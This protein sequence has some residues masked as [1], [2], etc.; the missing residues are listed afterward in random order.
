LLAQIEFRGP[1]TYSSHGQ[2]APTSPFV[3]QMVNANTGL[4]IDGWGVAHDP[5]P[6][7]VFSRPFEAE[8]RLF[9]FHNQVCATVGILPNVRSV[10]RP[11]VETKQA[12]I[13]FWHVT[14]G[15][16]Y[17]RTALP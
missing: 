11:I 6:P 13:S 10:G 9:R 5:L 17:E 1:E 12:D 4:Q 15:H 2:F 14:A 8:P 3:Q 7:S 16:D